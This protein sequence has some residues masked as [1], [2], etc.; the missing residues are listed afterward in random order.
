MG[1]R[2]QEMVVDSR[3]TAP[4]FHPRSCLVLIAMALSMGAAV[5]HAQNPSPKIRDIHSFVACLNSIPKENQTV[6]DSLR[7]VPPGCK[8]TV[9][10]SE[11]SAQKACVRDGVELPRVIFS[12]PGPAPGLRFRP[13]FSLCPD[14]VN[15]TELGEDVDTDNNQ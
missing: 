8:Y 1:E 5:A 15:F 3:D 10:A 12:C 7:C 14:F 9:T 11:F 2:S 4:A 13:S 6:V